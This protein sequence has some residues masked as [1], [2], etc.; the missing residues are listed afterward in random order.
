MGRVIPLLVWLCA[1]C[2]VSVSISLD[3]LFPYGL[4]FGDEPLLA[5]KY[6]AQS[7]LLSHLH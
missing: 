2:G 5:G 7:P 6:I 3:Q 4:Q 1:L